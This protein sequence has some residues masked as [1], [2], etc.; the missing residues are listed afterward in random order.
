[1]GYQTQLKTQYSTV[2][3]LDETLLPVMKYQLK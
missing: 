2:N 1:M 3:V